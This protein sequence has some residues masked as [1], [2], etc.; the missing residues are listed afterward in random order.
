MTAEELLERYA[1]GER[2]FRGVDLTKAR[3]ADVDLSNADFSSAR[4]DGADLSGSRLHDVKLIGASL[5]NYAQLLYTDLTGA[6]LTGADLS[7]AMANC[8][9]FTN[10]ILNWAS[11]PITEGA[12]HH[13]TFRNGRVIEGPERW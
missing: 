8:A 10:A 1:A 4:L 13:N 11:S 5:T 6:D 3:L 2:D 7:T 9:N 12:L